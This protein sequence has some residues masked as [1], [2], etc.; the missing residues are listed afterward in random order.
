V[1]AYFSNTSFTKIYASPLPRARDTAQA[2]LDAQPTPKPPHDFSIDS[3]KERNFGAAEEHR[4]SLRE[5]G[6]TLEAH[7]QEG[8][9][10]ILYESESDVAF[11][12]G[13][14]QLDLVRRGETAVREVVLPHV[15]S[16]ARTGQ[17]E[18]I[19]LVSHG[20]CIAAIVGAMVS[21]LGGDTWKRKGPM[22]NTAWVRVQLRLQDGAPN[23][24]ADDEIP[25]LKVIVTDEG[26]KDHLEG[27]IDEGPQV[28]MKAYQG[29]GVVEAKNPNEAEATVQAPG[30]LKN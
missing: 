30:G 13:E 11:P 21:V 16:A 7:F 9:Y 29:G 28:G 14:S 22:V 27:L 6:K 17:E 8:K 1:G 20:L 2:V 25:P 12:G 10:P 23:E 4:P 19:A 3:I 15:L 26:R 24:F 18:H 5:E